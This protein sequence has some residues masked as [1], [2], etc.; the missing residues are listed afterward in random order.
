MLSFFNRAFIEA[1]F[2]VI[3]EPELTEKLEDELC[4]LR[5][6]N[7]ENLFPRSA[8]DYLREWSE[9]EKGWLRRFYAPNSDEPFFDLTPSAEKAVAWAA[10]LNRNTFVGTESRL[11]IIFD[12]LR[13]IVESVERDPEVRRADQAV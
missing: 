8:A 12:L 1:N 3:P 9:P 10:S 5:E 4:F 11:M 13:Q 6:T 2:K 7:G